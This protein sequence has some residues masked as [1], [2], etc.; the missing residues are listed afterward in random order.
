ME[1]LRSILF[2]PGNRAN[3][4]GK[5]RSV[6]ADVLLLDLEDSVPPAEKPAAR[7]L[8][9]QALP[10]YA[11]KG[12]KVY[13]RVNG[14]GTGFTEDDLRAVV[15]PGLDGIGLPKAE[16]AGELRRADDMLTYLERERG[17]SAG[18]VRLIPWIETARAILAAYE[19]SAA[20]PRIIGVAF[21]A[22]DYTNDLG[23]ERTK[24]GQEQFYA[25]S[26]IA[27]AARAADVLAL[28]TPYPDFRDEPGLRREC[29]LALSLGFKGKFAIHPN[30]IDVLNE[31]FSPSPEEVA[32][33][34]KVAEAF[35]AAVARGA[36]STS[37]DGKMIDIPVAARARKLLEVAEAI[38]KKRSAG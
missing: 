16:S 18:Q 20:S 29:Q 15:G 35:A 22:E 24:E 2:V 33:A 4:V 6:P 8:V 17:L 27:V 28:D 13:V 38:A 19:I 26:V 9:K 3:M 32:S 34:Q 11:L 1:P 37:V 12:Q 30:Q 21:G 7:D 5:A 36:A 14:W 10:G 23:V 31:I 25:R